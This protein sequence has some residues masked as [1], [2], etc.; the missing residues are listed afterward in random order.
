[1]IDVANVLAIDPGTK[2]GW[3][4]GSGRS[5]VWDLSVKRFESSGL[6]YVKLRRRLLDLLDVE[7][8]DF[9]VFEAP[10]SMAHYSALVVLAGLTAIIEDVCHECGVNCAGISPT[11]VKRHAT[12][13][14]NAQKKDMVAAAKKHWPNVVFKDDNQADAMWLLE[15]AQQDYCG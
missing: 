10:R 7:R 13:K 1:M 4:H 2:C 9:V 14:G 12:G 11:A 5:G 15:L 3:A 6:R 8:T